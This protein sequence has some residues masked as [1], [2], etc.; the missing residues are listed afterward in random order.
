M[1]DREVLALARAGWRARERDEDFRFDPWP[2]DEPPPPLIAS[3]AT[4]LE[5]AGALDTASDAIADQDLRERMRAA[6]LG[7]LPPPEL[8]T[9]RDT[10]LDTAKLLNNAFDVIADRDLRKRI[11]A[12]VDALFDIHPEDRVFHALLIDAFA[13]EMAEPLP[14][15]TML[16]ERPAPEPTAI[17]QME[18]EG[19]RLGWPWQPWL[20]AVPEPVLP[21]DASD[22]ALRLHEVWRA[23]TVA[24]IDWAGTPVLRFTDG[25]AFAV[26]HGQWSRVDEARVY[27]QAVNMDREGW[28]ALFPDTPSPW[29]RSATASVPVALPD[30][31]PPGSKPPT[32]LHR[33]RWPAR[34]PS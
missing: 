12:V 10:I 18:R 24:Y 1:V 13:D 5:A 28:L 21:P 15:S 26:R 25:E 29:P 9:D 30:R 3:R 16:W 8:T 4:M 27:P 32:I 11:R 6:A 23:A 7:L 20:P 31:P 22:F 33:S 19:R 2:I 17:R 34:T 14:F